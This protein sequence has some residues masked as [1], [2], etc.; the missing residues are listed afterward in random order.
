M[1]M[2]EQQTEEGE[3]RSVISFSD[4]SNFER[5]LLTSND[6]QEHAHEGSSEAERESSS[7][8]LDP[9]EDLSKKREASGKDDT[10][11]RWGKH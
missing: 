5:D 11:G 8:P 3:W 2:A 9:N 6:E 7:K 4:A 10:K 1:K